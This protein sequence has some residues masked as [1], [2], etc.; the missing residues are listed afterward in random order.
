MKAYSGPEKFAVVEIDV[1][2]IGDDDVLVKI[3]AC[4][5]FNPRYNQ[6]LSPP[7]PTHLH[8]TSNPILTPPS[9]PSGH[10]AT[11]TI[12]LTGANITHLTP[13]TRIAADALDPCRTCFHCIRRKPLLCEKVTGYG[14]NAPGGI[15]EYCRYP[16]RMVFPISDKISDL[17]AVCIEPAAC[18]AHGIERMEM[19]VGSRVLLF[20]CGPTGI[21]L[22]QLVKMNGAAHLTIASQPGPKLT[23]AQNLNIADTYH[24]IPTSPTSPTTS[25][26][27]LHTTNPH[28][29]D[30]VIEATGAPTILEA[31]LTYVRKGG[32]LV[33][34]GVYNKDVKIAWSPFL[35]WERE[36]TVL[37]S[38]CSMSHVPNVLEYVEAGGLRL[39]G[40]VDRTFGYKELLRVHI[41]LVE[42]G[43]TYLLHS[44]VSGLLR[45]ETYLLQI[46]SVVGK[47]MLI[48]RTW[49]ITNEMNERNR[50]SGKLE[51]FIQCRFQKEDKRRFEGNECLSSWGG[52]WFYLVGTLG[53]PRNNSVI[54]SEER[55]RDNVMPAPAIWYDYPVF[56]DV[57]PEE[58]EMPALE[59]N[60]HTHNSLTTRDNNSAMTMQSE[61]GFF[62][63]PLS[64]QQQQDTPP[65]SP[66]EI[67]TTQLLSLPT[68]PPRPHYPYCAP[69]TTPMLRHQSLSSEL[70]IL[71]TELSK[72][73]MTR[74]ALT[75]REAALLELKAE[76]EEEMKLK[77]DIEAE[78][79]QRQ[80]RE[81]EDE[82]DVDEVLFMRNVQRRVEEGLL[83]NA[84]AGRGGESGGTGRGVEKQDEVEKE[85]EVEKKEKEKTTKAI[86]I[87]APE[88]RRLARMALLKRDPRL[89]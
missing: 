31:A 13:G 56:D 2:Q 42:R 4:V 5:A 12:V 87:S 80:Q 36:L 66:K 37:A 10:E 81:E 84:G 22:A 39:G 3:A 86:P 21:L 48:G 54:I 85:V 17:E 38:F 60:T 82:D 58:E 89:A 74:D 65:A 59:P 67:S 11:G 72:C 76:V 62:N 79:R 78:E 71:N 24:T 19:Q 64:R 34:Y 44:R 73:Q 47:L 18:A 15:A 28:G 27:A 32:K 41:C 26:A 52:S 7:P 83:K 70:R 75:R 9:P 8:Q 53:K 69:P 29:F 55:Q 30:I 63:C 25:L 57:L 6:S 88:R 20:G 77:A 16:A 61:E 33:I 14:G 23:L 50:F 49:G 46:S 51:A 45:R 1:P 68:S 35:I 43:L 40:I